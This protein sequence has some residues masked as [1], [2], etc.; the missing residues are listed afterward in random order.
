TLYVA[1][2]RLEDAG[3]I[4]G[5]FPDMPSQGGKRK[6]YRISDAG[7]KRYLRQ[8]E[9]FKAIEQIVGWFGDMG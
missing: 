8:L 6:Y 1:L 3:L 9:E 4:V 7:R 5:Y 2:K